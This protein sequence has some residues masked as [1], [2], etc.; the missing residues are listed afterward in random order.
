M[1][2][3]LI[4]FIALCALFVNAASAL[5]I[6][7]VSMQ[8]LFDNYYKAGEANERLESLREQAQAEAQSKEGELQ[9]LVQEIQGMQEEMEN[10]MLSDEAKT[11]KQGE[12]EAKVREGR[13]KQQEFQQWQ[14]RTSNELGQRSQEVRATLI[15]EIAGIVKEVALKEKSADLVFDTSDIIGSGVPTVLYADSDL[16]ITAVVMKELNKNAPNK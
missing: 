2:K 8:E 12:I 3:S 9:A 1:K 14:Q 10:P 6:V 13:Q 11:A 5:T 4:P 16:D 15:N 7:T